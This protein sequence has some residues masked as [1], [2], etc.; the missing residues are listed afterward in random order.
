MSDHNEKLYDEVTFALFYDNE[1][2]AEEERA[3]EAQLNDDPQLLEA[4]NQWVSGLEAVRQHVE[5]VEANYTLDQFTDRVMSA[6]PSES[7]WTHSTSKSNVSIDQEPKQSWWQ[8]W[9]TPILV[10]GLTAAAILIIARTIE[11]KGLSS[12]RSTVLI[13]YPDQKETSQE[14][15]VIWLLDEEEQLEEANDQ[16]TSNDSD[17]EDI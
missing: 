6:L 15:P 2:D 3:F 13:N 9:F 12:Q 1:L 14:A 11:T 7:A 4:Y 5:S 16:E 8:G 10:G 17:E